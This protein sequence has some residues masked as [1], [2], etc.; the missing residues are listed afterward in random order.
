MLETSFDY[1][2]ALETAEKSDS[3]PEKFEFLEYR[4]NLYAVNI[5][6]LPESSYE[7]VLIGDYNNGDDASLLDHEP[8][9]SEIEIKASVYSPE[10][11]EFK[12]AGE[13]I[14]NEILDERLG[15]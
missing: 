9:R 4:G 14:E 3:T 7:R 11:S 13:E 10:Y 5:E 1:D 2:T 8:D 15:I 12:Q 6:D